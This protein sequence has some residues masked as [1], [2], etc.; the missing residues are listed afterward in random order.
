MEFG[1][2]SQL[3]L[4]LS[5][6][7]SN[8][9]FARGAGVAGINYGRIADNLPSPP[10]V[11]Q[12]LRSLGVNRVK[13]YD[14]D[15]AVLSAFS[16]SNISLVVALPNEQLAAAAGSS[17]AADAWVMANVVP[18]YPSTGI[19]AI[20]VGNE[21]F[22]SP[23]NLTPFLVPAMERVYDSLVKHGVSSIKVSSPIALSALQSSYPP[24]A[25]A[26]KGELIQSA[27]KPMLSFL[28]RTGSSLMV[29][30]YPYFAYTANTDKI[31]LDY[32]LLDGNSAGNTDPNNGLVYKSLFEAQIDA[33]YAAM[34]AVGYDD[35][36]V[37]VSETGWPS[38]G[39]ANEVGASV[40]NAAAYNGNLVRRVLAG[41]GTPLRPTVPLNVYLFALFNENQK[42]GPT[43][44]RNYGLFYPDEQKVYNIPLTAAGLSAGTGVSR[45]QTPPPEGAAAGETWCVANQDSGSEKLQRALDYACGEGGANCR[46]IQPGATCYH[47][48]SL[49]AHASFAFNSYYQASDRR[50]GACD[51]AG[52][53]HVVTQPP[54][55]GNCQFP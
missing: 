48:D 51:F 47:P 30:A 31:P 35:V 45:I 4:I 41:N 17:A 26:F 20:T 55:Y 24:S 8:I 7:G 54:N 49:L 39:D 16:G 32:A 23:G 6:V 27:I 22:V 37:V 13:I 40:G 3:L 19:E 14:A 46:P 52:A 50:S 36:A 21:V 11:V 5:V 15:S 18:Y 10:Q 34:A 42:T 28:R 2:V 33:V 12:L 29:N 9:L 53:A 43:S 38:K 1:K 25:G 44:E